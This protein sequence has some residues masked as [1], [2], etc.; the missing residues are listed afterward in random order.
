MP[1]SYPIN[2]TTPTKFNPND[3]G[4][5]S[6]AKMSDPRTTPYTPTMYGRSNYG[7]GDK[8]LERRLSYQMPPAQPVYRR[9]TL[10]AGYSL[11]PTI[12]SPN[13]A[14]DVMIDPLEA[15]GGLTGGNGQVG[16][17]DFEQRQFAANRARTGIPRAM[18]SIPAYGTPA[19]WQQ[20][21]KNT[22]APWTIELA[23]AEQSMLSPQQ[24]K[25]YMSASGWI[26]DA[27]VRSGEYTMSEKQRM[28][29][30]SAQYGS[31]GFNNTLEA[32]QDA[33]D[34]VNAYYAKNN[35]LGSQEHLDALKKLGETWS[36]TVGSTGANPYKYFNA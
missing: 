6:I 34:L 36:G 17:G 32:K 24:D 13:Q 15:N 30:V 26:P 7:L 20:P 3:W 11:N 9:P 29:D 5:L 35:T 33:I 22:V 23:K 1:I 27:Q 12:A 4:Y 2:R 18:P 28:S 14:G 25:G 8:L 21:V 31:D 16:I 19:Y 10:P